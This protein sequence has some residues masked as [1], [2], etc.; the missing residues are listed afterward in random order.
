MGN[1][2]VTYASASAGSLQ[3]VSI[4]AVQ[5]IQ[6]GFAESG[7]NQLPVW[8]AL[9]VSETASRGGD[10]RRLDA[11]LVEVDRVQ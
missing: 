2:A 10:A 4:S 6:L 7:F 1:D 8:I 11:R 3:F 5:V 9:F